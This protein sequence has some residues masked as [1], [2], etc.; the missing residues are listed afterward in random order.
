MHSKSLFALLSFI[1]FLN[2]FFFRSI[3]TFGVQVF[4]IGVWIFFISIGVFRDKLKKN[5]VF[6]IG[7]AL[8]LTVFTLLLLQRSNPTIQLLLQLS[9]F[10]VLCV[11]VYHVISSSP[12]IL[13]LME[14][15]MLPLLD[16]QSYLG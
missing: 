13:A 4:L 15:L 10:Y 16:L 14:A 7:N 1:A 3:G 9:S 11:T 8:F 6:F 5:P 2:L 12:H